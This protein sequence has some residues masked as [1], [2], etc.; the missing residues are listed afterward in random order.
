MCGNKSFTMAEG[1]FLNTL[2]SDLLAWIKLGGPGIPTVA[3][4][5][6]KC[7]FVSQHSAVILGLIDKE[8]E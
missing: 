6:K 8:G 2:Q 5:C 4:V 1:Y 7:G 3:I